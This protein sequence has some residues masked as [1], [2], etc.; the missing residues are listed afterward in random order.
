MDGALNREVAESGRRDH[1][2]WLNKDWVGGL[3]HFRGVFIFRV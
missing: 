1:E 2:I 3:V